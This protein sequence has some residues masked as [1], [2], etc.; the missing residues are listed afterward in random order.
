MA[1]G[2]EMI[3]TGLAT[4]NKG[5]ESRPGTC[6][7]TLG[8]KHVQRLPNGMKTKEQWITKLHIP[9]ANSGKSQSGQ[10]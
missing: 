6:R 4:G 2:C 8:R 3:L 5:A 10:V 1:A 9:G 7:S